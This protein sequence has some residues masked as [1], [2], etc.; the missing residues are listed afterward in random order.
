MVLKSRDDHET[1]GLDPY[2]A[3][4]IGGLV[5]PSSAGMLG[6]SW[7]MPVYEMSEKPV[8]ST[9]PRFVLCFRPHCDENH[10][11]ST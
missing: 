2:V 9:Q 8:S 10:S 1:G 5:I 6:L 4:R 3:F 7:T 11:S